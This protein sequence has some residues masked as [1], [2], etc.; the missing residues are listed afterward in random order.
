[1]GN[2]LPKE[3]WPKLQSNVEWAV[4]MSA[5]RSSLSVLMVNSG[6]RKIDM[7]ISLKG[8]KFAG[9]P[10]V[11]SVTIPEKYLYAHLV[12]GERP[13]WIVDEKKLARMDGAAASLSIGPSTVQSVTIPL[14]K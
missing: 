12:P 5:D 7:P 14:K 2:G 3:K 1:M 10:V 13:L 4:A 9:A 11:K 8:V 6:G